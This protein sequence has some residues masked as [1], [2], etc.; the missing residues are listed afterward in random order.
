MPGLLFPLSMLITIIMLVVGVVGYWSVFI[1]WWTEK[2]SL[3]KQA[4]LGI[5][6]KKICDAPTL[7]MVLQN[8]WL[9]FLV[10]IR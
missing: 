1:G 7:Y 8:Y 2:N 6:E 4:I 10:V 3:L 5:I 9:Y